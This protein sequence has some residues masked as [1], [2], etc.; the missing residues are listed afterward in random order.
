MAPPGRAP[1][2]RYR[3]WQ[4]SCDEGKWERIATVRTHRDKLVRDRVPEVLAERGIACATRHADVA[5]TTGLLLAKLDE[6]VAELRR[7][8]SPA[9]ALDEL[10]DIAEVIRALS[11]L[12]GADAAALEWRR[13]AKATERGGFAEGVVLLWT[14]DALGGGGGTMTSDGR[15]AA[16][17]D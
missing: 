10:A 7:A 9:A 17:S 14:D 12:H 8:A 3:G 1:Q 13:A 6:E 5:E 2:I 11:G 4:R 16:G 15:F